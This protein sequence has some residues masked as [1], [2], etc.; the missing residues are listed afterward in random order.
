MFTFTPI[1]TRSL[2]FKVGLLAVAFAAGAQT[3]DPR[4]TSWLTTY[5]G[6]YARIYG[7]DADKTS[8]AAVTTWSNGTQT[9][10]LPAYCGIQ[11][12]SYSTDWVYFRS[13]G[14]GS[15]IMGPWYLNAGR[16]TIFP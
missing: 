1:I 15:H 16:S 14:L 9:Q 12:V 2:L 11:E 5:S 13:T 7:T 8:G 6:K 10:S 4:V 3:T